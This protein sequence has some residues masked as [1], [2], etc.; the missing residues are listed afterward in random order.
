MIARARRGGDGGRP[1]RTR[2][3]DKHVE[4]VG[5]RIRRLRTE[6][7]LSQR[8]LS[9]P[10]VTYAFVSRVERGGRLP[11]EKSLRILAEQLG[12][13][14]LY[15]ETGSDDAVCPHCGRPPT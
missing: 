8:E 2:S 3:V 13:T 10:G 14:P 12:V 7:G 1:G 6:R 5:E 9:G 15:L 4:S 11:S